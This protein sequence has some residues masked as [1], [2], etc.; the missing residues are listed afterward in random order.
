MHNDKERA[1]NFFEDF[2]L[3][4]VIRHGTHRTMTDGDASVYLA[5]TGARQAAHSSTTAA[6]L[7]GFANRPLDDLLVFNIAFGKTVPDISLNAIANLGYAEVRFVEPVYA[8]DTLHC[9]SVI[10]GLKE[11]SSRKSGVIYVRSTCYDQNDRTVL[12]W[13]R[14]VM[15]HKRRTASRAPEPFVPGFDD[16]VPLN[17]LVTHA[18]VSSRDALDEW[19]ESTGSRSMW[20]HFSVGDRINHLAGMT[21]EEADHMSAT[22]LY[23]N[24]SRVHFDALVMRDSP[25][26]RRLV[27]GGHVISV[28]RA[29]SYDGLENV[30]SIMAIN[31]GAHVAPTVAG[32]TL[33]AFTE[34]IQKWKLPG[35]TDMGALRL[36]LVGLKNAMPAEVDS[37]HADA[38]GGVYHPNVVLDLDYTVLMPRQHIG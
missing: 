23:Q 12:S 9:E 24:N 8:G 14:W 7:M 17:Q 2:N 38:S 29:L 37:R 11:N 13:V 36:R 33:Y 15:V 18:S 20:E 3:G 16:V 31:A 32:D 35:R 26:G 28:C 1:G 21:I 27:Y 6:A 30:V 5:L 22:R 34:V 10:L 19:C 4:Q 25:S